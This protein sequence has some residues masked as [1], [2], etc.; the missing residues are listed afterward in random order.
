[1]RRRLYLLA[2]V[3]CAAC[4]GETEE[5]GTSSSTTGAG[6]AGGGGAAPFEP[7]TG[8]LEMACAPGEIDDGGVCRAP[9]VPTDGCSA[10]FVHDGDGGCEAVMPPNKCGAGTMALPGATA[11]RPVAPCGSSP[12]ADIAIEADTVFV[13]AAYAGGGNN[14]SMGAPYNT[15][16]QGIDAAASGAIVAVAPGAYPENLLIDRPVRVWGKCPEEVALEPTPAAAGVYVRAGGDNTELRRFSVTDANT[17]VLVESANDVVI[18]EMWLFDQRWI[19]VYVH[20]PQA[21][22]TA[23]A[24]LSGTLVEG[25]VAHGVFTYG[26]AVEVIDSTVRGTRP[27]VGSDTDGHGIYGQRFEDDGSQ[28]TVRV[29]RSVVEDNL[30]AGVRI[31]AGSATIEDSLIRDTAQRISDETI[32]AGVFFVGDQENMA[33]GT[34]TMRGSVVRDNFRCAVCVFDADVVA[35]RVT[36]S[37]TTKGPTELAGTG[38]QVIAQ[39]QWDRVIDATFRQSKI[40]R[41]DAFGA[42]F[43]GANALIESIVIRD[44]DAESDTLLGAGVGMSLE[45][46]PLLSDDQTIVVRGIDIEDTHG[47]GLAAIG[48]RA[49][50]ESVAIRDVKANPAVVKG[51]RG[52]GI[53]VHPFSGDRADVTL[54]HVAIENVKEFGVAVLGS[55]A[56]LSNGTLADVAPSGDG[57]FGVGLLLQQ[58]LEH[59]TRSTV[60]VSHWLVERAHVSGIVV[61]GADATIRNTK[62]SVIA[63]APD[64]DVADGIVVAAVIEGAGIGSQN[65]HP[66]TVIIEDCVVEM[67]QRA[68][69]AAFGAAADVR[70]TWLSC[71]DIDLNG[72][73]IVGAPFTIDDGGGNICTCDGVAETCKVLSSNLT[74]PP[75]LES[76]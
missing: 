35:E 1:M 62:T 48:V 12:W 63:P 25:A 51:G 2:I 71:N 58:S 64:L 40:A 61:A 8:P 15:I 43:S 55:D 47:H 46:Q 67:S 31:Y 14:G 45:L 57:Q 53:E 5:G 56:V 39:G 66:A 34:L 75:A 6:G 38:L 70:D 44:I 59:K 9:G 68:G 36:L 24:R 11:C 49:M 37:D 65:V 20:S 76:N 13:D 29:I 33:A 26:D 7:Q 42:V 32:G 16:Q 52:V 69:I 22:A 73:T 19:G 60:D 3:A 10:G 4:G 50:I 72:E 18:D 41:S 27:V 23:S 17:A 28:P 21:M 30:V 54:D 74:P